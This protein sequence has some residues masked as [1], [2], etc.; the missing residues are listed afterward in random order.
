[1]RKCINIKPYTRKDG[2][3]VKGYK[4]CFRNLE[5]DKEAKSRIMEKLKGYSFKDS[6]FLT[7][8]TRH[9][10]LSEQLNTLSKDDIV[11]E[12]RIMG[13]MALI[14]KQLISEVGSVED[15][16]SLLERDLIS[17]E[18]ANEISDQL[19]LKID[20]DHISE[21][22]N[23][24][25]LELEERI[26]DQPYESLVVFDKDGKQKFYNNSQKERGRTSVTPSFD[27]REL[28]HD[29]IIT[30]NHPS[31]YLYKNGFG[32]SFSKSD[33]FMA[34]V[35]GVKEV[36]AV[37]GGKTYSLIFDDD[38]FVDTGVNKYEFN[39]VKK[40][41]KINGKSERRISLFVE[42]INELH[43]IISKKVIVSNRSLSNEEYEQ[44][45]NEYYWKEFFSKYTKG[46][47][48]VV[49]DNRKVTIKSITEGTKYEGWSLPNILATTEGRKFWEVNGRLYRHQNS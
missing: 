31:G 41:F 1:M 29:D 2:T 47:N 21:T 22:T 27:I 40:Q 36:R 28:S 48:F 39:R 4:R 12:V 3:R 11:K 32:R 35:A 13:E 14:R 5:V 6:E 23:E 45:S 37:S 43:P 8:I 15:I 33:V 24:S 34:F 19:F 38:F 10:E 30:H 18:K 42:S 46:V 9:S 26:K 44:V 7:K 17:I 49:Q 25:L 16:K 20:P